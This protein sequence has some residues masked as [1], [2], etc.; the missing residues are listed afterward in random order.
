MA[1]FFRGLFYFEKVRRYGD[2]PYYDYVI[3]DLD[4]AS[5]KRPRDSRGYVMKKVMDDL[6]KAIEF[7]PEAWPSDP[8]F[9]LSKDAARA[10]KSRAA[11][12][13]GTFRKYHA[14]PDETVDEVNVSADW[15]LTQAA[16]AAKE[17][18][19][20]AKYKL[21]KGNTFNLNAPYREFFILEDANADETI[22]SI[23]FNGAAEVLVRHGVQFNYRNM[24]HSGTRRLVDHYLMADGGKIQDQAGYETMSYFEQFQNR[25]PRMSQ[26]LMGPGY[27]ELGGR[28]EV[29]EDFKTYDI[30]G[31]RFIKHISDNTHDGATTST[32]DWSVFRYPEVLLNYAE[33]KAELG[34]LTAEDVAKTIDLIRDRV[35]MPALDMA[36]AN[37][38]PDP[39]MDSFYPNVEEGT[40][41]GV[42][43][44]IRRERTV[45]LVCEGFR[46]WDMLRWRE[47][48][49]L[50]PSSNGLD[51]FYGCYF[52][53][54]GEHDMNGDNQPDICLWSGTKPA[55]KEGVISIEVG[56]GKE[57]QLTGETSGYVVRFRGYDYTWDENRD[58]LWPIPSDQRVITGGALTQNPG[59]DDGLSF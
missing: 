18:M 19:D 7:L 28:S 29:I 25:D 14:I 39:L 44:E 59:Y 5:L 42:I 57:M 8:L 27:V 11:L 32:T 24:R 58:Y 16:E 36:A 12:F 41:K 21:Y 47:G 13:E 56:E 26:T 38:A 55:E 31:Y 20:R 54:L 45:E 52:S 51:G 6:D 30:T 34:E 2:M 46:Q 3:S 37:A 50:A 43:L 9:R 4:E 15:F 49:Q 17:V 33:A 10:M 1:Y 40:N 48:A 35:G 53:A 22:F 23:C